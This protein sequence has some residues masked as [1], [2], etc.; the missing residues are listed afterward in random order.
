MKSGGSLVV[1]LPR[2]W[3]EN[4]K[5]KQGDVLE[6]EIT[7]E[8]LIMRTSSKSRVK[9]SV[10]LK[11]RGDVTSLVNNIIGGYLLGY[12]MMIVEMPR[13]II[14]VFEQKFSNIKNKLMGLEIVEEHDDRLVLKML[15]DPLELHPVDVIKRMWQISRESIEASLTAILEED[16]E[17]A[18]RVI[19]KDEEVDKL[20][21]YGVRLL[22]SCAEEP[23]LQTKL[24]LTNINLLDY[25]VSV[26]LLDNINDR[27]SEISSMVE[28]GLLRM[29]DKLFVERL[30]KAKNLL[31]ENHDDVYRIF[32]NQEFSL[33]S[34][35]IKR[36]EKIKLEMLLGKLTFRELKIYEQ[37]SS[38]ARM[39]Y[40]LA[41]LSWIPISS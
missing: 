37:I 8:A 29:L 17:L 41:E 27:A 22:R 12:D 11:Y 19:Q 39:Q 33:L 26:Y 40:D 30:S 36:L 5:L 20:Y 38:M 18:E 6:V 1:S 24:N 32:F 4:Q 10:H 34:N 7:R 9:K 31:V 28:K 35:V 21:F 2:D 3:V 16:V 13:E 14:G 25:R 23:I 15:M